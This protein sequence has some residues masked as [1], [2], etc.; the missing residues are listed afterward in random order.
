MAS[1]DQSRLTRALAAPPPSIAELAIN[2][3]DAKPMEAQVRIRLVDT[4]GGVGTVRVVVNGKVAA[5]LRPGGVDATGI[6]ASSGLPRGNSQGV[7]PVATSEDR[8]RCTTVARVTQCDWSQRL[9]LVSGRPSE[10]SILAFNASNT[11]QAPPRTIYLAASGGQEPEKLHVLTV[12]VDR[13]TRPEVR[14]PDLA[15]AVKDAHDFSELMVQNPPVDSN[16]QSPVRLIRATLRNEEA[17][18]KAIL[19]RL[20]SLA[21]VAAPQDTVV[22]FLAG[23]AAIDGSARLQFLGADSFC[24]DLS[25]NALENAV[26]ARELISALIRLPAQR[27]L[28]VVDACHAG[29]ASDDLVGLMDSRLAELARGARLHLLA[30]AQADQLASDGPKGGNGLFT[31]MLMDVIHQRETDLNG[32]EVISAVEI[33]TALRRRAVTMGH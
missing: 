9:T 15:N 10:V 27:V 20:G 22:V 33:A 4:G 5:T 13:L 16:T 21:A 6:S 2:R 32:D 11:V 7:D 14:F 1:L 24:R 30:G 12:G 29:S 17:S 25:C 8:L 26:S 3:E 19:G 31:G 18:R 23:H 28:L